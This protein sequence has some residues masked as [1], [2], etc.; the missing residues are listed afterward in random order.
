MSACLPSSK[1]REALHMKWPKTLEHLHENVQNMEA[2]N[3]VSASQIAALLSTTF[4]PSLVAYPDATK[5][6]KDRQWD[7]DDG[8]NSRRTGR[9][10]CDKTKPPRDGHAALKLSEFEAIM[11]KEKM[12]SELRKIPNLLQI[13]LIGFY[14]DREF[15]LYVS[16]I[17][18]E[19]NIPV[20]YLREDKPHG[21]AGALFNFRDVIM[22]ECPEILQVMKLLEV[23]LMY[24]RLLNID[25]VNQRRHMAL[26]KVP[27]VVV[28]TRYLKNPIPPADRLP[29]QILNQPTTSVR[30]PGHLA[31]CKMILGDLNRAPSRNV[32]FNS[33]R[34]CNRLTENQRTTHDIEATTIP[35][36]Y[37]IYFIDH[38]LGSVSHPH[39]DTLIIWIVIGSALVK[40]MLVNSGSG[41]NILYY[42][43]LRN[44]N[45]Q[46][47]LAPSK[48]EISRFNWSTKWAM[49][50][51]VT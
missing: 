34:Q 12:I 27:S 9:D 2:N 43:A 15:A 13:F 24:L 46:D 22:E 5:H 25:G 14:D 28:Y 1:L 51:H 41:A 40:R 7:V 39:D 11:K 19:L 35:P 32:V 8:R 26:Q 48:E 17:S 49:G 37:A 10:P 18:S 21:S 23:Y 38:D 42:D 31:M 45:M 50:D 3:H 33:I 30:A 44:M 20:R 36:K 4:A 16:A 29:T 47:C 6:P